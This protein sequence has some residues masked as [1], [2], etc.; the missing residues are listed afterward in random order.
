M[1]SRPSSAIERLFRRR[2]P[3]VAL[4]VTLLVGGCGGG[5]GQ[6]ATADILADDAITVGSFDF[7]ESELLAHL[8]AQALEQR[9][10]RVV[11]ETDIGPRELVQPALAGGLVELVPDYAGTTLDFLSLG[12]AHPSADLDGTYEQ[13]VDTLRDSRITALTPS[14]AQDANAVVVTRAVA[15]RY[16]LQDISDLAAVADDLTFGGPPECPTRP[17]CLA[18]LEEVYGLV[19][20]EFLALDAGGPLTRQALDDGHVDVALLFTTDPT[21]AD[22]GLVVLRDDRRLQPAENVIPLLRT[23]VVDRWGADVVDAV[24]AV[25]E[26]L[27]TE[28]LRELN[29]QVA[30]GA[31]RSPVAV[32]AAWLAAEGLA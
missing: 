20:G 8:Y 32:A 15:L 11:L 17:L 6:P 18:G 24:D 25:S 16:D 1:S 14:R 27:T 19:F 4:F 29:G 31:G 28:E 26:R 12:A 7:Q 10:Y 5:R 13:L 2:V 9:G 22:D 21:T 30:A 23:E 3:V